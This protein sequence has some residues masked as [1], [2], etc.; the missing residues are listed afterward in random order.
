[1]DQPVLVRVGGEIRHVAEP[2]A[3]LAA[4][5]RETLRQLKG[6]IKLVTEAL[7]PVFDPE[8]SDHVFAQYE[9]KRG[10]LETGFAEADVILE[11]EY[12]VGHQE[13]LYIE[14]NAIIAVPGE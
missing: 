1:D 5:D 12:R 14:N 13:Q 6:R 4:P 9:V 3:L 7:P 10:D 11:G 8:R 2:V